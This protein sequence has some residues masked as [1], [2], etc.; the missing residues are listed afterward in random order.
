MSTNKNSYFWVGGKHACLEILNNP[1]RQIKQIICTKSFANKVKLSRKFSICEKDKLDRKFND[2]SFNHQ[3]IAVETKVLNNLSIKNINFDK[4]DY[5]ILILNNISDQRNLG[6]I[7]RSS[8]AFNIDYVLIDKRFFNQE[9]FYF[10]KSASGAF[11]NQKVIVTSNIKNDILI[12]KKKGFWIYALNVKGE[13]FVNEINFENKTAFVI[14]SEGKGINKTVLDKCDQS[15]KININKKIES[16][17]VS[18]AVSSLL[19]IL[20]VKINF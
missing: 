11:E 16:L 1:K 5:K 3:G 19:A 2:K 17:N 9:S 8:L 4:S 20:S 6:S 13:Y 18:N 7:I 12:L 10:L 14:G 15:I